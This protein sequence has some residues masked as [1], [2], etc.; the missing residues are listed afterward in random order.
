MEQ[1]ARPR[2]K[3]NVVKTGKDKFKEK[4][5]EG[6]FKPRS[7]TTSGDRPK[8]PGWLNLKNLDLGCLHCGKADHWQS[9][10]KTLHE[11]V[12]C[13]AC[14]RAGCVK[15]VC[16]ETLRAAKMKAEKANTVASLPDEDQDD[17]EVPARDDTMGRTS[18]LPVKR[19]AGRVAHYSHKGSASTG[20][21]KD[22]SQTD[23]SAEVTQK[24]SLHHLEKDD[25]GFLIE[26]KVKS[27]DGEWDGWVEE[28]GRYEACEGGRPVQN[29]GETSDQF[30]L[31]RTVSVQPGPKAKS[32]KARRRQAGQASGGGAWSKVTIREN[33]GQVSPDLP[34]RRSKDD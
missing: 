23:C 32:Q 21:V 24:V 15:K 14:G 2:E 18:L 19:E 16:L 7:R 25:L 6:R 12:T 29:D 13:T 17:K 22:D 11:N 30:D 9:D 27:K 1:E 20:L 31:Q 26:K 28:E 5:K 4:T 34:S 33:S 3:V 8:S 10:C